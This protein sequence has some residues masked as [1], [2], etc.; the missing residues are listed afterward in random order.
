MQDVIRN[1]YPPPAPPPQ[2]KT[3]KDKSSGPRGKG[4]ATAS[5]TT[6]MESHDLAEDIEEKLTISNGSHSTTSELTR[7]QNGDA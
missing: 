6:T 1:A 7:N 3:K 5:A 4:G 2:K